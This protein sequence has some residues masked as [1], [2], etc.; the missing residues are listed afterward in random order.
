MNS[1]VSKAYAPKS[2]GTKTAKKLHQGSETDILGLCKRP[3]GKSL[4]SSF[5]I[6]DIK[7]VVGRVGRPDGSFIPS[8]SYC[9]QGDERIQLC[10]M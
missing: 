2:Q 7:V 9:R 3:L 6:C 8:S 5:L 1:H 4:S 10:I